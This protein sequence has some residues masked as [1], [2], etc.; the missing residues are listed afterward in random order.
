MST[1]CDQ[2]NPSRASRRRI[3]RLGRVAGESAMATFPY[4]PVPRS[5]GNLTRPSRETG[6]ILPRHLNRMIWREKG[7]AARAADAGDGPVWDDPTREMKS[8]FSREP[9][10]SAL[11]RARL[12]LAVKPERRLQTAPACLLGNGDVGRRAESLPVRVVVL[13]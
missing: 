10:A 12:R 2:A 1:N 9:Q 3:R 6:V 5:G 8:L 13:V 4:Q 7:N 11:S